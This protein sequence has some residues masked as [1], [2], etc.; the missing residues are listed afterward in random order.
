MK[1]YRSL[2]V[3]DGLWR[4]P[5]RAFTIRKAQEGEADRRTAVGLALE[6]GTLIA[7]YDEV[8]AQDAFAD[9]VVPLIRG[10]DGASPRVGRALLLNEGSEYRFEAERVTGSIAA[11]D[12]WAEMAYFLDRGDEV[13][14]SLGFRVGAYRMFEELTPEEKALGARGA[15]D[16][17]EAKELSIVIDGAAPGAMVSR[18]LSIPGAALKLG[19]GIEEPAN[20]IDPNGAGRA[21]LARM[22]AARARRIMAQR[23]RNRI[24]VL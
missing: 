18:L 6:Y 11:A 8:V 16:E 1:D 20:A 7:G 3:G 17:A 24:G 23:R 10:H 19:D 13:D 9:A 22:N 15:I 14:V 12:A 2:E 4:L 21:N 5:L